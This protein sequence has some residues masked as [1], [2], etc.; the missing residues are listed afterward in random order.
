MNLPANTP[1]KMTQKAFAALI[2]VTPP[3]VTKHKDA[4]R[5]VMEGRL[6]LVRESLERI[7]AGKDPAR[8]GDRSG[9]EAESLPPPAN[10]A[11]PSGDAERLN[12]NA[13]AAREKLAAAQLRE[14]EL[15]REA[16]ELILKSDRDAAEFSRARAGRE[17]VMSIADRVSTQLAPMTD[18]AQIHAFVSAECRKVCQLLESLPTTKPSS[19]A[20][21]A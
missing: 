10:G 6:V 15:A 20:E 4:G 3:M 16:G 18:P 11:S 17:A 19:E 8:G 14:L 5:L 2:G 9:K 13:Q 12:Y 1:E 7:H 21:A